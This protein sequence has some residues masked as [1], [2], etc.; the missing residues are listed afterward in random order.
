[1]R[2]LEVRYSKTTYQGAIRCGD[3]RYS[4]DSARFRRRSGH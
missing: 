2:E 4:A 1:M 3:N